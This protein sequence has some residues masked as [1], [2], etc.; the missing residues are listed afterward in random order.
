MKSRSKGKMVLKKVFFIQIRLVNEVIIIKIS[1]TEKMI[2]K[3]ILTPKIND[4]DEKNLK[5]HF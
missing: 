2:I 4:I 5:Y 1:N 3:E